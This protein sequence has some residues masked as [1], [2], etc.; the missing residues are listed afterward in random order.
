M[1]CRYIPTSEY[2][3]EHLDGNLGRKT[4]V[5]CINGTLSPAQ[6]LDRDREAERRPRRRRGAACVLVATDCLSEGVNLQH[7][8]N[9]IVHYD[10]AWNPTRHEQREGRVDR[11]GQRSDEVRVVTIYGKDNGI[12]GKVLEVLIKKHRE[13]RKS[14]GISV[15]GPRRDL[16]PGHRR[17][18]RVAADA[19]PGRPVRTLFGSGR[20]HREG[21]RGT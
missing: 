21:R 15:P 17:D 1:F 4:V 5:Q 18:R 8:F 6:R 2:V 9:A 20:G 3:A 7:S 11:F 14:T 19:R 10:L 16:Q 13:I 12:D